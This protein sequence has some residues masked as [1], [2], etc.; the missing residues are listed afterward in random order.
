MKVVIDVELRKNLENDDIL[1]YHDGQWI[2]VRKEEY[3]H[4]IKE[5]QAEQDAIRAEF[6][7]FKEKVNNKLETYHNILQ[8]L[9]KED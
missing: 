8:N 9:T 3:F 2:N 5:L 1:I 4:E 7:D 6:V